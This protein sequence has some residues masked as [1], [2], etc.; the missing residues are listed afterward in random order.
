[1]ALTGPSGGKRS[2]GYGGKGKASKSTAAQVST[3]P[4]STVASTHLS[5]LKAAERNPDKFE[6]AFFS[7]LKAANLSRADLFVIA[8]GMYGT[9]SSRQTRAD[10]LRNIRRT[11]DAYMS[12]K[13]GIDAMGGRSA[14]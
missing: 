3:A 6:S 1:M 9:S 7:A 11:H 14:A 5:A 8:K 13:R 10:L 12:A 2:G 4:T